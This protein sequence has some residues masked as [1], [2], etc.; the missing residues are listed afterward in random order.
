[1]SNPSMTT[2]RDPSVERVGPAGG[3]REVDEPSAELIARCRGG[4]RQAFD[5]LVDIVG[6]RVRRLVGRLVGP[7]S[8]LDDLVQET[9]V[10]AWKNLPR[11]RGESRFTTWLYRITVNV[12]RNASRSR[13]P[14]VS[15]S[16]R[17]EATLTARAD[18]RDDSLLAA[19]DEALARL[20]DDLRAVFVLHESEGLS[21]RDIATALGCPIGT[22]MSRLHRA[23]R[24]LFESLRVRIEDFSP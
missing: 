5:R 19:Y 12:V 4:D 3:G 18:V 7:R 17:H 13:R 16:A 22:V 9:L 20:S 23:R 8:D 24:A 10:R 14:T 15:L 11:F 1:M 2:D 6:P 21:Y